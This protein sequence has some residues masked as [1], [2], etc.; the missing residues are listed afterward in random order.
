M[1]RILVGASPVTAL[2]LLVNLGYLACSHDGVRSEGLAADVM[3]AIAGEKGAVL[4]AFLVCVSVLTTINAAIFTGARTN[5][6]LG[7]DFDLFQPDRHLE[8]FG[9]HAGQR[10]SGAGRDHACCWSGSALP[11]R[12]A[13][14]RWSP[15]PRRFLDLLSPDGLALFR[16]QEK[17]RRELGI[18][19][20]FLSVV[21][22]AFCLMCALQ[23]SIPASATSATRTTAPKFGIAVVAGLVVMAIG[24]P[25]ISSRENSQEVNSETKKQH[26]IIL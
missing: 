17:G 25:L 6:A 21:P 26:K 4:V 11:P 9:Q 18:P 19:N 13:S 15:T 12:T 14:L 20:P 1:T 2:Y 10:G 22:A 5:Y 23:C 24:I 3:R 7:R 16:P 8:G